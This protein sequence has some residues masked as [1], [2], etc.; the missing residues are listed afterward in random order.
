MTLLFLFRMQAAQIESIREE[1]KV[2]TKEYAEQDNVK[3]DLNDN[4]ELK[5]TQNEIAEKEKEL[6]TLL[7]HERD[8]DFGQI[9]EKKADI[10]YGIERLV[11]EKIGLEGQIK[12][13][14]KMIAETRAEIAKPKYRDS[15]VNYKRAFYEN[16]VLT[17]TIEDLVTYCEAL[18]K[19][20]TKFHSDK[21]ERINS[22]IRNL[23]RTIYKGNDID[24]IQINTEEVRG[25]QKRRSYT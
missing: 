6:D 23:W 18:E 10:S 25:S 1:I 16:I 7:K 8:V 4:L 17:K 2:L 13:K 12:E 5:R 3:R 21:M 9:A 24:Y 14:N 22:V 19:A 15:M 20:L 11:S